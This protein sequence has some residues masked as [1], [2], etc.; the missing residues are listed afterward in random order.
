M[1]RSVSIEDI[2]F[3]AIAT[4]ALRAIRARVMLEHKA[5]AE[6][7]TRCAEAESL[8]T[9]A[10][11]VS[12]TPDNIHRMHELLV[13]VLGES[14]ARIAEHAAR[15]LSSTHASDLRPEPYRLVRPR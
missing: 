9:Y 15:Y 7:D 3:A 10:I 8:L 6:T 1:R 5:S 14:E 2:D 11:G 4:R 13:A 12:A